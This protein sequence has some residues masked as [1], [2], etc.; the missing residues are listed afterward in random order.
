MFWDA[1]SAWNAVGPPD[2]IRRSGSLYKIGTYFYSRTLEEHQNSST[3][4]KSL[5]AQAAQEAQDLKSPARASSPSPLR[6]PKS[7][8]AASASCDT[9][10]SSPPADQE[11]PT[12]TAQRYENLLTGA[13]ATL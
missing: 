2:R 12:K 13:Y 8:S 3:R 9:P 5:E 6:T 11:R 7:K 1:V 4:V 10:L